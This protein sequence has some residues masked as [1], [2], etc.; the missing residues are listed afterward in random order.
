VKNAPAKLEKKIEKKKSIKTNN[1]ILDKVEIKKNMENI[2]KKEENKMISLIDEKK[3]KEMKKEQKMSRAYNRF[4]KAFSQQKDK[5][6]EKN[7]NNMRN[8]DNIKGNSNKIDS[9]ASML[10]DHIM[11]PFGEIAEDNGM[12]VGHRIRRGA[13]VEC[14]KSKMVEY[15]MVKLLENVPIAKKNVKKP[16]LN[17]FVQ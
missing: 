9:L 11:K 2:E 3:I 16:K 7:A 5:E 15:N 12:G 1:I 6:T 13:S 17:K 4:K 8:S 10:K 14:R